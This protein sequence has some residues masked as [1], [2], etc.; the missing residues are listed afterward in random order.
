MEDR[1]ACVCNIVDGELQEDWYKNNEKYSCEAV[2]K[3][4]YKAYDMGARNHQPK[5]AEVSS[6]VRQLSERIG[7]ISFTNSSL[8]YDLQD[9]IRELEDALDNQEGYINE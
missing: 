9:I 1:F 3:A 5:Y 8:Y 2:E 6:L 7:P 4:L